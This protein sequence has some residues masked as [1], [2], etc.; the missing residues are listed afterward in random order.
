MVRLRLRGLTDSWPNQARQPPQRGSV[1]V[2]SS[3][4]RELVSMKA[5]QRQSYPE[6]VCTAKS[7]SVGYLHGSYQHH[8]T[9]AE[10]S[11]KAWVIAGSGV[12][13]AD[14][15][16][17]PRGAVVGMPSLGLPF[18]SRRSGLYQ[19]AGPGIDSPAG[20]VPARFSAATESTE[21][22]LRL[23]ATRPKTN[24]RAQYLGGSICPG[25]IVQRGSAHWR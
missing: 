5:R 17:F 2:S 24:L 19:Q 6:G 14:C 1:C 10:R 25:W 11:E 22:R 16:I 20:T 15:A 7:A 23:R 3:A 12:D 4:P 13:K 8:L 21:K 18:D 9:G